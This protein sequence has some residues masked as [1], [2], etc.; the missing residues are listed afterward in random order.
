M[1]PNPPVADMR[2]LRVVAIDGKDVRRGEWWAYC[3]EHLY[4]RW[5]ENGV[6]ME[7][8]AAEGDE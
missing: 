3:A 4:G 2:R 8:Y 6:V 7:W 1:C 5:L